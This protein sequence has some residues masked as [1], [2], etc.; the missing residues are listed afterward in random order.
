MNAQT[1]FSWSHKLRAVLTLATSQASV[2]NILGWMRRSITRPH[3]QGINSLGS[4][5]LAH[6][7]HGHLVDEACNLG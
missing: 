1:P 6:C 4:I 7:L 2:H 3:L 5:H